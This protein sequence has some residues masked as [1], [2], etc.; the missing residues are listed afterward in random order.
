[1]PR[2][3]SF[4]CHEVKIAVWQACEHAQM[5]STQA[6]SSAAA[7]PGAAG[8]G[9]GSDSDSSPSPSSPSQQLSISQAAPH[10]SIAAPPSATTLMPQPAPTTAAAASAG[11]LP[12]SGG[13]P[14]YTR[15]LSTCREAV[16]TSKHAGPMG[17]R[18]QWPLMGS[19]HPHRCTSWHIRPTSKSA[20]MRGP[21]MRLVD[22][23]HTDRCSCWRAR[24]ST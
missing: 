8:A 15:V 3:V 24:P 4:L 21:A 13:L 7:V 5:D 14:R 12:A 2:E 19:M 16:Q 1:M 20:L 9:S 22:S 17:S 23:M 6:A 18:P 10:S 11:S